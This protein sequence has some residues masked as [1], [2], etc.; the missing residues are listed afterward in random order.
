MRAFSPDMRKW[1]LWSFLYIIEPIEVADEDIISKATDWKR[2]FII[3]P[4]YS[5]RLKKRILL[6]KTLTGSPDQQKNYCRNLFMWTFEDLLS[7]YC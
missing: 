7:C 4:I 2:I 1:T 5:G 3:K 6:K